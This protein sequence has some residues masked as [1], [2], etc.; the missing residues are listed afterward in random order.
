MAPDL[1]G[2]IEFSINGSPV[3]TATA[4]A[5]T[6]VWQPFAA[7][8]NSG[9]STSATITIVDLNTAFSGN[10]FALDDISFVG[11][12]PDL[13]A[14]SLARDDARPG[15]DFGYEVAGA[16]PAPGTTAA[17]F[18][19]GGTT[20]A[21]RIV[22]PI[23]GDPLP[24][25]YSTTIERPVGRYGPFFVPD[26]LLGTPPAGATHLLLVVDPGNTVAESDESGG[27]LGANNV[28]ALSL[29]VPPAPPPPVPPSPVPP[30]PPAPP[31]PDRPDLT[32]GSVSVPTSVT[33]GQS[34]P[35]SVEIRNSGGATADGTIDVGFYFLRDDGPPG[36]AAIRLRAF[37]LPLNLGPG[38]AIPFSA[39]IDIP[40]SL[41]GGSYRL[42]VKA[43]DGNT[44]DEGTGEDNNTAVGVVLAVRVPSGIRWVG[45]FPISTS[46][47]ALEPGFG[48]AVSRFIRAVEGGGAG[49][50]IRSTLTP[51][52][53]AYLM[54]WSWMIAKRGY[55]ANE[56]PPMAGVYIEWWHGSQ[57]RSTRAARE[58][59]DG[60]GIGKLKVAPALESNQT[61]GRGIDMEI[62]WAANLAVIDGHG[63]RRTIRGGPRN[64]TNRSLDRIGATFGV[65]HDSRAW[66]GRDRW[67][68]DGR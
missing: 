21:A 34:M 12:D 24:P 5:S 37:P 47:G 50:R 13:A 20:F 8:W 10:D 44:I 35:V 67:S 63:E 11:P 48:G 31:S 39:T 52:E 38:L 51:P 68:I 26:S 19:A 53:R 29:P 7:D 22:D 6:G 62:T 2:R 16:S 59:I 32:V 55:S 18:W 64:S 54:H 43:D 41:P 1:A 30:V 61:R 4:P 14:T 45:E 56:V 23:T 3:G 58:M 28:L 57:D 27:M 49:V 66:T 40:E 33:A 9:A 46:P 25:P 15:V 60:F 42:V 17:L 65:I 36:V